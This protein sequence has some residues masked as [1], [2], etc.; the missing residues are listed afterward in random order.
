MMKILIASVLFASITLTVT[1]ASANETEEKPS[2]A[3]E[4]IN[5]AHCGSCATECDTEY[6]ECVES[7]TQRTICEN[8]VKLCKA[9]CDIDSPRT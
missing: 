9:E 5:F 6:G 3:E 4:K 1:S 7:G 8:R 2:Y